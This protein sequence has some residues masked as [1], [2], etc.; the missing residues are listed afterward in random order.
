MNNEEII[1]VA[2]ECGLV[3]NNNHDILNFA[4]KLRSAFKKEFNVNQKKLEEN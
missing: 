4:Q 3:Y 1:K 2:K